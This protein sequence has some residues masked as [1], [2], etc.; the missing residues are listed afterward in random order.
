MPSNRL[1]VSAVS[2]DKRVRE[3]STIFP[4]VMTEATTS[5]Q[6]LNRLKQLGWNQW[7]S[8]FWWCISQSPCLWGFSPFC[9]YLGETW[10]MF[11]EAGKVDNCGGKYLTAN[12]LSVFLQRYVSSHCARS[13]FSLLFEARDTNLIPVMSLS[14]HWLLPAKSHLSSSQT[15]PSG[16]CSLPRTYNQINFATNFWLASH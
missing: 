4:S 1:P 16:L 10:H 15:R 12:L 11:Q 2:E 3:S 9:F 13:S 5:A 14:A 8:E 7:S 6:L